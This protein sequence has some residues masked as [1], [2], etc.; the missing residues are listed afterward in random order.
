MN[1]AMMFGD[2]GVHTLLLFGGH[3]VVAPALELVPCR[4]GR[5][6]PTEFNDP[7]SMS[8]MGGDGG[9]RDGRRPGRWRAG[10]NGRAPGDGWCACVC[11][12]VNLRVCV[13]P[14]RL[15]GDSRQAMA[16]AG[17]GDGD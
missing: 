6:S 17:D 2:I 14:T 4:R 7:T 16:M 3:A 12:C 8:D 10:A 15:V 5:R 9:P 11:V 1:V 13:K